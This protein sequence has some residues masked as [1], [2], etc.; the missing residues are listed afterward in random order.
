[1]TAPA[2]QHAAGL[3]GRQ[4]DRTPRAGAITPQPVIFTR[5]DGTQLKFASVSSFI[6]WWDG[7]QQRNIEAEVEGIVGCACDA[8]P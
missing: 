3:V 2:P 8:H 6:A 4:I 5:G 7:E 1:M